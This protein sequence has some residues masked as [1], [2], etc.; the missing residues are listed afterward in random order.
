ML[1][2]TGICEKRV[3]ANQMN[4]ER[5]T[6]TLGQFDFRLEKLREACEIDLSIYVQD[7]HDR[8]QTHLYGLT[9]DQGKELPQAKANQVIRLDKNCARC[10]GNATGVKKAF[11]MACLLYENS[12]V[13][14][15]GREF[16]REQLFEMQT[17][18]LN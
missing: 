11:K 6:A 16:S 5:N 15:Q 9:A 8:H 4:I 18:C 17:Q 2:L 3:D 1:E 14:H 7:M 12:K 13:E 10:S